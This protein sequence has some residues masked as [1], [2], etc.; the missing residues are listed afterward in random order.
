DRAAP[1]R[2]F[3]LH[4]ADLDTAREQVSRAFARHELH[5][6][7][8]RDLDLRLDLA[9][10]PRLTIGRMAYGTEATAYGPPMGLCYHV[11]LPVTGESTVEQNGVRRTIAKGRA[12]VAFAPHAPFMVHLSA[13]SWQY[14]VKLP[15]DLLEA[16]AARLTGLPVDEGV[17][18]DV[19]FDLTSG[20]GQALVATVGFLYTELTRRDGIAGIPAA[21]HELESALMTQLL[22]TVPSRLSPVLHS[23]PAHTRRSR[24]REVVAYVDAHPDHEI[25]TADLAAMA[26]ISARALQAG[27]R[28]VVGM[29]PTAYLRTVRLDRVHA[30]LVSGRP[31][32]VTEV[33]AR[34]GFFHPGRFA[35]H[36]RERFGLL[37]SETARR[38]HP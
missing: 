26:G 18:F 7:D 4:T 28:E 34:W 21:C 12:G 25:T 14:H 23:R 33:A 10:S 20:P 3:S 32:H 11:N 19:T 17:G 16:H 8:G 6:A 9:P 15:K 1:A 5:L 2:P 22:M 13:D 29:S 31:A 38:V 35:H 37:P 27:F 36:Y 24:I 30:A